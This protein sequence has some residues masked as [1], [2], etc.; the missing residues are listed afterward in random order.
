MTAGTTTTALKAIGSGAS[1]VA[2]TT[3]LTGLYPG[4]TYYYRLVAIA[5]SE[6]N[7]DSGAIL[8]FKTSRSSLSTTHHSIRLRPILGLMA[9]HPFSPRDALKAFR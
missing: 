1:P 7:T 4:T 8:S 5:T 2:V 3:P 9:P 6:K